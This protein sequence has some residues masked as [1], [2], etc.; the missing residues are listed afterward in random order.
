MTID[1]VRV[2]GSFRDPSG[3]VFQRAGSIYRQVNRV[4]E[5]DYNF[6]MASGLYQELVEGGLL[7]RH[8]DCPEVPPAP[9]LAYKV[10][11]PERVQ[12][13]SY[14]YEWSFSQLKDAALLQLRIARRALRRGMILRDASAYNIQFHNG[15]PVLI[16]TLSFTR[17]EEGRPWA[18]YRQFCQHFLAPLALMGY[19]DVRLGQ[20][21]QVHLDGIP[22]DLAARLLPRRTWLVLPLLLHIHLHAASQR[23]YRTRAP[24]SAPAT[25]KF[26]RDALTGMLDGLRQAVNGLIW[27]PEGTDWLNYY[28]ESCEY[29]MEATEAKRHFVADALDSVSPSSVWDLGANIGLY[30]RVAS[31]RGIPSLALDVDPGCV[32]VN[33]RRAKEGNESCLLPLLSD[34]TN[35]SPAIGWANVERAS[36]AERGPAGMALALALIHHLAIA[37]NVPLRDIAAFFAKICKS[38]VIEFVPKADPKVLQL[39]AIRQDV[40]G[41]YAVDEFRRAFEEFFAVIRTQ[42][43]PNSERT[44]YVM[45]RKE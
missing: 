38:L 18:A 40:F 26:G 37:N 12:F 32:E 36:L 35:P 10:I 16:D 11:R 29:S 7:L 5:A 21:L 27:R 34:L 30:T 6:L 39:L 8:E 14:P 17:Y 9:E 20:L 13:I 43:V 2:A 24:I 23:R 15:K 42:A 22:L 1:R 3:F 25:G 44:L 4:Y 19:G 41:D 28:S 45:I 33:Y 31:S